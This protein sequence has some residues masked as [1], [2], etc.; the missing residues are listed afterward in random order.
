[1][2][3]P[4]RLWALLRLE[5]SHTEMEPSGMIY[6][7]SLHLQLNLNYSVSTCGAEHVRIHF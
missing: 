1:M 2:F 6:T 4:P 7:A 5:W 3:E